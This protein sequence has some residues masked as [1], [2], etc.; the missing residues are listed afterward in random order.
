MQK[1]DIANWGEFV[2][3]DLFI[4]EKEK[5]KLQVPTGGYI[6]KKDLI[7]GNIPRIT[8]SGINNGI[9]GYYDTIIGNNNYREYEN[10]ISVSFLGTVFYQPNKSSLDMKVHCLKPKKYVLN[11]Y[12]GAFLVSII[13]KMI[14][15]FD[16]KD[17]LSSTLLPK[18]KIVL[19][20][21]KNGQPDWQYMENYIKQVIKKSE[22]SLENLKRD[23]DS[24]QQIDVHDWGEF[25]IGDLFEVLKGS[26]LTKEDKREGSINFVST[27]IFNNGVINKIGNTEHIHPANTMV[28]V[29]D[30]HATGRAYYQEEP[31]WASD[32]VNVLYPKFQL[33]K[34][35]GLYL[36]PIFEKA[37]EKFVYTDKWNKEK[38]IN[39]YIYLP[40]TSTGEPDWQYMENYMKNIIST[41]QNNLTL[42]QAA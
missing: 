15:Y 29:Y 28:V 7:D 32:S 22:K 6:S 33:N 39:T 25:V 12:S 41:M 16:Y 23:D 30:G 20:I 19:P 8:V 37:G 27:S 21:D 10:F 42:F 18:L 14:T 3:G 5:N 31:Y 40:I 1:I 34:Y 13:R 11:E 9:I 24:K 35:I 17:Q 38:M 2:I 4:T 26:R 36:V